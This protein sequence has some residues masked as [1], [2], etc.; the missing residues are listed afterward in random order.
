MILA[1]YIQSPKIYFQ[2]FF[3]NSVLF[4]LWLFLGFG[5][6]TINVCT[7]NSSAYLSVKE[8][9]QWTWICSVPLYLLL[10]SAFCL[11]KLIHSVEQEWLLPHTQS[12][13]ACCLPFVTVS[14]LWT[15]EGF[16]PHHLFLKSL[17]TS[18]T[19]IVLKAYLWVKRSM[20][21][22]LSPHSHRH[23]LSKQWG[24]SEMPTSAQARGVH[25][26]WL[27]GNDKSL[28]RMS[29]YRKLRHKEKCLPKI[30]DCHIP[31]VF[32]YEG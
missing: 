12:G 23:P 16:L 3:L 11:C 7:L 19:V 18:V 8:L 20:Q 29:S 24:T 13:H 25:H 15:R 1:Y 28:P 21:A 27:N 2:P 4:L 10:S 30:W 31:S 17:L 26:S 14:P 5:L 6:I 22:R 9:V 32:L